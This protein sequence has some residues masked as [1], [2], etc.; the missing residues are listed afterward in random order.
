M[1]HLEQLNLLNLV[2][3]INEHTVEE[4]RYNKRNLKNRPKEWYGDNIHFAEK[5]DV[6]DI[7]TK[8]VF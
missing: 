3:K 1:K 8:V 7:D 5:E 6:G 2:D 4:I